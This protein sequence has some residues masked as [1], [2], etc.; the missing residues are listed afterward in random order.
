[1]EET[2]LSF[3][4]LIIMGCMVASAFFSGSE[5]SL[6][7][8]SRARLF[9]LMKAG[10]R[11]ASI[12][13]RL[14]DKK[15]SLIGTVLLGN[16]LVNIAAA[17][18]GTLLFVKMFGEEWG[19]VYAT[20]AVTLVVLIFCEVL[21]KTVAIHHTE[22]FALFIARPMSLII[23]LL[24]PLTKV[25]QILVWAI[26]R[27]FGVRESSPMTATSA[28]EI[29]RGS[30]EMHHREGVME[31]EDR[32][33][34]GSIIDLNEREVSEIMIHRKHVF[35]LDIAMDPEL[36][37][38]RAIGS[39]HSRIPLYKGESENIVGVI[40][41][42]DLMKMAREQR[43]GLTREMIRRAAQRPWFVPE[44][45]VLADQLS[46]FRTKRKHFA[47]VVNEYGAWQGIV[48][49]EDIIEEIVGEI[50]DEHD[51][52]GIADIIPFGE[53][54]YKVAGTVTIRDINRQLG[55]NLPDTYATT[56]AGLVLHE[57]RCIPDAG[58][59]FEF[60][61]HRFT[62]DEKKVNQITQLIVEKLVRDNDDFDDAQE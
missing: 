7:A 34:L 29:I 36:L 59:V 46:A 37:L 27:M 31:K 39:S 2:S 19:P 40:H 52:F 20:V 14:R 48:T 11:N 49:L 24:W 54:A 55:W 25:V 57:A 3:Y 8:V 60:Y 62:V 17:S 42:K 22:S 35:S 15:D 9:T 16:T 32:D 13:K 53:S 18:V 51:P 58:A 28:L 5:T 12:V 21:P 43:I 50:D 44:T 38:E 10:N 23:R 1:M 47:C 56:M 61:G 30:I 26:L 33:M 4:I 6:T 41:I 45:T